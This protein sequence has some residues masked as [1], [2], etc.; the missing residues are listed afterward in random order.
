MQGDT[1]N[2]CKDRTKNFDRFSMTISDDGTITIP[3]EQTWVREALQVSS[4]LTD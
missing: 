4:S 2:E 1:S 3:E